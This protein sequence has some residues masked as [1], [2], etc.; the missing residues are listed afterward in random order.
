[1]DANADRRRRRRAPLTRERVLRAAI[2]LADK[3]GLGAVSMRRLG[4]V[5][6]VEA[7]SLYKHVANKDD[8]LDGVVDEVFSEI[9]LPQEG[10]G[11]RSAMR[12]RAIQ[13]ATRWCAT[14]GRLA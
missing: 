6:R 9:R 3:G 8:L 5:L 7:M 4:Q 13:R 14:R 1:M 12:D 2:R 10:A 11:W